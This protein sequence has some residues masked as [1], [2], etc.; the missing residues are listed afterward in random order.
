M[1]LFE[2]SQSN[3]FQPLP[4]QFVRFY[5]LQMFAALDQCHRIGVIHCD[6]QPE[7]ILLVP[8][9]NT[10][11]KLIDFGSGSFDGNQKYEDIQSRFYRSPEVIIGLQYGPPMDF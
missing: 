7:N 1:N 10:L 4:S 2:L 3:V 9:S 6:I 8:G 11:I 5:G